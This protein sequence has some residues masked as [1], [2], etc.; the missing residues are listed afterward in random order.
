MS[1]SI[2]IRNAK[3]LAEG[4]RTDRIKHDTLV[5]RVGHL[6]NQVAML[7]IE[8]DQMKQQLIVAIVSRGT[9]P[10]AGG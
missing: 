3:A 9:G 1:D 6:E 7:R 4:V 8:L 2:H 10:T 5:D